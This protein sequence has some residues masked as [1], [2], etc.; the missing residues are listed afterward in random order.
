MKKVKIMGVLNLAPDSF[1]DGDRDIL[2]DTQKLATRLAFLKDSDIIDVGCESSRP[3]AIPISEKEEM[4]RLS[5]L[6][7]INNKDS[8]FSID[9]YKYKVAKYA[10]MNGFKMINDI[11]AGRFNDNKMFEVAS[12]F[13]VP[14][15]L[16]HM[17]GDPASMQSDTI[18]DSVI[19]NIC[20]FFDERIS[21]AKDY[22]IA[23]KN[24][25]LDPGIGFGKSI[26]DNFS[27]V[28]NIDKFK[29][30]GYKVLI[31]LS[32]KSFLSYKEDAPKD[33]LSATITMNTLSI[34]N[35][36]DIIRVHDPVESIKMKNT[37]I[38]YSFCN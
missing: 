3:G 30:I 20:S 18:Y 19:D 2:I 9:T 22:G 1:Y 36:A 4:K 33:R 6:I 35:G 17:K 31:G 25:I 27:I 23:D 11:Y 26:D 28:K 34:L 21:I 15:V 38:K 13:N 12:D 16:M 32:R 24:I 29:R 8:F 10:L 37:L 14:I 7:N 5:S